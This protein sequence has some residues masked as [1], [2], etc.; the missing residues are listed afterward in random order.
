MKSYN[1]FIGNVPVKLE[2]DKKVFWARYSKKAMTPEVE[3]VLD[4]ISSAEDVGLVL[5]ELIEE[6]KLR[7]E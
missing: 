5:N 1:C 3:S 4:K 7:V 2:L 6:G